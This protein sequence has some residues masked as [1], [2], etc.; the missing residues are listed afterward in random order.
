MQR[1]EGRTVYSASDLNDYLECLHLIGLEKRVLDG[2]LVRPA[3][4]E[5]ADLLSRKGEEHELR[6]LATLR[7]TGTAITE[8]PGR[9]GTSL[10]EMRDAEAAT[11]AAMERGDP[12]IYQ[13]AFFDEYFIGRADFLRRVEKASQRWP[14]SYEV[15]DAKLARSAKAYF[16]IQLSAYSEHVARL[17]GTMPRWMHVAL[18]SG[19]NLPFPVDEYLAY[20]RRLKKSFLDNS[21]SPIDDYPRE[22]KHCDVCAWAEVCQAKR[23]ADDYLGLVARMTGNQIAK[24]NG[25]GIMTVKELATADDGLRPAN[26]ADRSFEDLR[27]QADLQVQQREAQAAGLPP[28]ECYRYHLLP[29]QPRLGLALL[30]KPDDGDIYFDIEGDPYYGMNGLEYLF[31]VYLPH[32]DEYRAFWA[33]SGAEEQRVVED[34]M[35]FVRER[36]ERHPNLHVYHYASYEKSALGRLTGRYATRRDELDGLLRDGVFCDLYTVV[37]QS[38]KISQDSYSIKKLEPFYGFSRTAVTKRGDDSILQFESWLD[39]GDDN[40]LADIQLYNDEDCRS[41]YRLLEW[42]LQRRTELAERDALDI[43]WFETPQ[44]EPTDEQ[45]VDSEEGAALR[46]ALL[47]GIAAPADTEALAAMPD[48]TRLRFLLGHLLDYHRND[49]KSQW[50]EWFRRLREWDDLVE[51]DREA[52]GDLRYRDDIAPQKLKPNDRNLA[53]TYEFPEQDYYLR[54]DEGHDPQTEKKCEISIDAERHLVQVKLPSVL[55]STPE[56]LR[57]L[58]PGKPVATRPL[59]ESIRDVARVYLAGEMPLTYPAI[60]DLLTGALPRLNDRDAGAPIQPSG[61]V[62]GRVLADTIDALDGSY[63]FVQGPPG[64][65]KSFVGGDAV[66]RLLGRGRR[67][68]ILTRSHKAAH[69]LLNEVERA[70]REHGVTFSGAHGCTKERHAYRSRYGD[71]SVI[72]AQNA[73]ALGSGA[74]LISG[75]Q[76]TFAH[77]AAQGLFDVLVVDEAGQLALADVLAAARSARNLVVVGAPSPLAQVVPGCPPPGAGIS[78]LE[79]LLGNRQ[80][81]P[82]ERG[83][84]LPLSWRMHPDICAFVSRHVYEGRLNSVDGN[85]ANVVQGRGDLQGSGLRWIPVDHSGNSRSSEEEAGVVVESIRD[86]LG[87]KVTVR[88]HAE[89]TMTADDVLVVCAYNAQ[90]ALIESKL[91]EAGIAVRVGTVDTFQGQQA[92]IVFYSMATSSGEDMPRN[93]AFLFEKNRFNVAIS[94]AQCLTVLVCS[95]RLLQIHCT[96]PEQMALANLLCAYA[97]SAQEVHDHAPSR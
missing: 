65:G 53:F 27:L 64:S 35:D 44:D 13:P 36:R 71:T 69:N 2:D 18:G 76:W 1:L 15:V 61:T 85:E 97:E 30:P 23:T 42:L 41:T 12:L 49:A 93:M 11:L 90:R 74:Q 45:L 54:D 87:G 28:E 3:R 47:D 33:R 50:W 9:S 82:P 68:G 89:R 66:A 59:I 84:F 19:E 67:I 38:L 39:S 40:I 32:E 57:A 17:Q 25:A 48:E 51:S 72:S 20:Y 10:K 60:R 31:G 79:H 46:R 52:L 5:H 29:H 77:P 88:A 63:L 91:M 4:S 6:Y 34:F 26:L 92:P 7:E 56:L 14:W 78:V 73:T 37:R 22:R 75:T 16:L 94:R 81:V 86:L 21:A 70:A 80:T 95:P 62:D 58:I 24:L 55:Q 8:L 43:P 83:I 96:S